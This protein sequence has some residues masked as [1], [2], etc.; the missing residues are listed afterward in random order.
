MEKLKDLKIYHYLWIIG[1]FFLLSY[2]PIALIFSIPGELKIFV[3][4][5]KR[6]CGRHLE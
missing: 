6:N 5:L 2:I 4:F 1:L 3:K